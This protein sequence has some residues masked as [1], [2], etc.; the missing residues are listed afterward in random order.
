MRNRS[1]LINGLVIAFTF[2]FL[3]GEAFASFNEDDVYDQSDAQGFINL[4]GL[5]I[6]MKAL[7]D[8]KK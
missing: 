3:M 1:K 5:P 7:A 4:Y 8:Q 2:I 6:K